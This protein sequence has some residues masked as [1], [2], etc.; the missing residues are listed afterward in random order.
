MSDAPLRMSITIDPDAVL[1]PVNRRI[2]GS[3][4]E[5][6]GRSVYGGLYEPGHPDADQDGL[7]TD[8][9]ARVKDSESASSA[10]Q[11]ETSSPAIAGRTVW[12]R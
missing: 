2:F 1:A 4:V 3:F 8:V 7:R 9:L 12:A 10:T 11:A 6:M 5:H